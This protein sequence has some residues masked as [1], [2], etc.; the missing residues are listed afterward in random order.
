[1]RH[2]H[3]H[4]TTIA[5]IYTH[6]HI[7]HTAHLYARAR[8]ARAGRT[9]SQPARRGRVAPRIAEVPLRYCLCFDSSSSEL[10]PP[11]LAQTNTHIRCTRLRY[12]LQPALL[13][14]A[15]Q[16]SAMS[17]ENPERVSPKCRVMP[18]QSFSRRQ[19]TTTCRSPTHAFVLPRC[20]FRR[21]RHE[22]LRKSGRDFPHRHTWCLL[23][24]LSGASYLP[25]T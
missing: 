16:K 10:P 6:I 19:A 14:G 24:F 15:R 11:R 5:Q 17:A 21:P 23:L 1:M 9:A 3:T 18:G 12:I 25:T 4:R 13:Q 22:R 8:S 7:H 2:A 20:S